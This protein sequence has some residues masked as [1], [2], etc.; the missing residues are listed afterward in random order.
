MKR[1]RRGL[2]SI[3]LTMM[4]YAST[5]SLEA[6]NGLYFI[7]HGA[8]SRGMGGVV[9]SLPQDTFVGLHNPAGM[10]QLGNRGDVFGGVTYT[11]F[12]SDINGN[13]SSKNGHVD[14]ATIRLLPWGGLGYNRLLNED[15]SVG[16]TIAPLTGGLI[17]NRYRPEDGTGHRHKVS[18]GYLGFSPSISTKVEDDH[19]IGVGIDMV[20]ARLKIEGFHSL[21]ASFATPHVGSV[22]NNGWDTAYGVALRL[23][24]LWDINEKVTFGLS[25]QTTTYMTRFDK[26]KGSL[27]PHGQVNLPPRIDMGVSY[28]WTPETIMAFEIG[29]IANKA[30]R[31]WAGPFY[32]SDHKWGESDGAG[33]GWEN[34]TVY[35]L[36]LSHDF[37]KRGYDVVGRIGY[38]YAKAPIPSHRTGKNSVTPAVADHHFTLGATWNQK[39]DSEWSFAYVT[40][41]FNRVAGS[42]GSYTGAGGGSQDLTAKLHSLEISYAWKY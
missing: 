1:L 29:Q 26:Y 42:D 37:S 25:G 19:T 30:I 7:S 22:T 32:S 8:K 5:P 38:N 6:T 4:L 28:K 31:T 40:A 2:R 20:V 34:Q 12:G 15:T 35:K 3:I 11:A 23:G 10:L 41:P 21:D 24:W 27:S 13:S 9:T 18:V 14:L 17:W 36:G 39:E 16:I 33:L